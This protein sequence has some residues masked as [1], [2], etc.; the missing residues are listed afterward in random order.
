MKDKT[1]ETVEEFQYGTLEF[2]E[3]R[4]KELLDKRDITFCPLKSG[5]CTR[6]CECFKYPKIVNNGPD[7]K[8]LFEVEGGYCTCYCLVGPT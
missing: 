6:A 8:P 1:T 2:A 3:K 7:D 5:V 4:I